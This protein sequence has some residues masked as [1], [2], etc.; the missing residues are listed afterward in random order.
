MNG[1]QRK[2]PWARSGTALLTAG[3]MAHCAVRAVH[4]K[5]PYLFILTGFLLPD[6]FL[7]VDRE[8]AEAPE[9]ERLK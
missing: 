2:G 3:L 6:P 7:S 4:T 5:I 9:F 1:K 8:S